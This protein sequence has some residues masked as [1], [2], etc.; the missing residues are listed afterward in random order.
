MGGVNLNKSSLKKYFVNDGNKYSSK[1]FT[2]DYIF[3]YGDFFK[4][5]WIYSLLI[6]ILIF[7]FYKEI[8]PF[9]KGYLLIAMG[10]IFSL[11][12]YFESTFI[13]DHPRVQLRILT[14]GKKFYKILMYMLSFLLIFL[15][16]VF[17]FF[18]KGDIN[19]L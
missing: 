16:I 4:K 8:I 11:L 14:L 6:L 2:K 5:Y 17:S 1:N 18:I 12:I 13:F 9:H 7:L 3:S 10:I 19:L 15:G